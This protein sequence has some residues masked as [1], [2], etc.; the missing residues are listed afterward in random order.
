MGFSWTGP[1]PTL[2]WLWSHPTN[3][4]S[5]NHL[6]T[7]FFFNNYF[8]GKTTLTPWIIT[9]F[10]NVQKIY[11]VGCLFYPPKL[12]ISFVKLK[13]KTK[14]KSKQKDPNV[15]K[16][17]KKSLLMF[18][19]QGKLHST[20]IFFTI[21]LIIK[22]DLSFL[23][24]PLFS[25]FSSLSRPNA[26]VLL[27]LSSSKRKRLSCLLR[28]VDM[29]FIPHVLESGYAFR[30]RHHRCRPHARSVGRLRLGQRMTVVA[31]A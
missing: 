29:S 27:V 12:K 7:I 15:R 4:K 2:V 24:F 8:I 21:I 30:G 28:L 5:K 11:N 6:S 19:N 14:K 17:P 3:P 20:F 13:I 18:L 1:E 25:I 22:K 26:R 23:F 10:F 31:R 16:T 9:L